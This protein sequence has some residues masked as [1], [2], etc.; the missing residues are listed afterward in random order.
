M[1]LTLSN[2][3]NPVKF[4]KQDIERTTLGYLLTSSEYHQIVIPVF[5]R[6]YCWTEKQLGAWLENVLHGADKLDDKN[7]DVIEEISD[8]DNV[9]EFH[10]VGIGRFKITQVRSK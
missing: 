6:P 2:S 3:I 7:T 1:A 8:L 10:S 9:D 5:Q 4:A